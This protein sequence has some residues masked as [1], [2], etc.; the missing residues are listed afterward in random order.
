M[1]AKTDLLVVIAHPDDEIFASGTICLCA[2]KGLGITVVCATHGEGGSSAG[3]GDIRRAEL[4]RSASALGA[5]EVLFLGQ[6]DAAAP[7]SPGLEAWDLPYVIRT[8]ASILRESNPGLVLTH[9]PLGGYGHPAHR[10]IHASAMSAA[11][12]ASYAG[13]IFS[14]CGQV[15]GAFFS[16][17]FDQPSDVTI[18]ARGFLR[19]RVASLNCHHSQ[20]DFFL[21][22]YYPRTLRKCLSAL[23]GLGFGFTEAGRKRIPIATAERFFERFPREGL[24]L[25]K[26]PDGGG[27]FFSEHFANDHRV[28]FDR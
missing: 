8:L 1:G 7:A 14:F 2:E 28:R 19:Q 17:H 4:E 25:H 26:A 5:K 6:A 24:V 16:W 15:K 10:L 3:H 18:D 21:Q 20:V 9:G 22:P 11:R 12:D 23:F 27:H 13:S